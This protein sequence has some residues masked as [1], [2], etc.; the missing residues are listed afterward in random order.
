MLL[1]VLFFLAKMQVPADALSLVTN[2]AGVG[3]D[4]IYGSPEGDFNRGGLDP[5]IKL[6]RNVFKFTYAQNKR[7]Y[8]LRRSMRVPDDV[9]FHA[10]RSC[11]GTTERRAYSG[12]RSYQKELQGSVSAEG[13]C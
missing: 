11:V 13:K 12:A 8:Y 3:Y 2:Y 1:F 4:L 7:A 10:T 5:G 9:R 6:T